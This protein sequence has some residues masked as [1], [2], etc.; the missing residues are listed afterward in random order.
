[1]LHN[2]KPTEI[3]FS[4]ICRKCFW[5]D[6]PPLT[7]CSIVVLANGPVKGP[8]PCSLRPRYQNEVKCAA[9]DMEMIFHSHANKTHF[10]KKSCELCLILK[11]RIFG[12]RSGG[13]LFGS[14]NND[15]GDGNKNFK[16]V[17]ICTCVT[18][19]YIS[20]PSLLSPTRFFLSLIRLNWSAVLKKSAPG[21]FAFI[22]HDFQRMRINATKLKNTQRTHFKSDVFV[23][24]TLVDAKASCYPSKEVNTACLTMWSY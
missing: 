17:T 11:V 14:F 20:L 16:K 8:C 1:M 18:L 12:T 4:K 10:D 22:W 15:D 23:T 24:V 13:L 7:I 2:T 6:P 3:K 5:Y 9:F 19:L 21:K